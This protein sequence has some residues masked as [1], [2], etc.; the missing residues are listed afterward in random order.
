MNLTNELL[1]NIKIIKM[2]SWENIF[3]NLLSERRVA[4]LKELSKV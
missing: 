4:E 1:Q 3:L 2:Y